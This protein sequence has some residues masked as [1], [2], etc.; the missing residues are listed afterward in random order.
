MFAKW[1]MGYFSKERVLT[2]SF[3]QQFTASELLLGLTGIFKIGSLE[4]GVTLLPCVSTAQPQA[5]SHMTL[6]TQQ[7]VQL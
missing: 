4:V 1:R 7:R 2:V 5:D 6:V 3:I